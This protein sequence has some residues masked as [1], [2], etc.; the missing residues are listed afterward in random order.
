MKKIFVLLLAL[1]LV[2][3]FSAFGEGNTVTDRSDCCICGDFDYII[4][5][6]GTAKIVRY[7]G[8][9][10]RAVIPDFL[11]G[12][13]VTAI[14]K[15]AFRWS[16]SM[17]CVVLPD[18]VEYIEGNPFANCKYL[19]EF[20][21]SSDHPYLAVIDGVLFSKLDKRLICYPCMLITEYYT[22]PDGIQIIESYAFSNS[23]YLLKVEIPNSVS[24]I[25]SNPFRSCSKMT[26]F[27]FDEDHPY[28][29]YSFYEDDILVSRPDKRLICYPRGYDEND[30]IIFDGIEIIG[31]S[32]CLGCSHLTDISFAN[33]V[34]TIED[35]AFAGCSMTSI[36]I[37]DSVTSIGDYAFSLNVKAISVTIPKS[38]TSI[39]RGVFSNCYAL[40]SVSIPDNVTS[41]GDE[42]FYRCGSLE[43]IIIPNSVTNI[44]NNVF[45]GCPLLTVK[46]FL[47]SYAEKYCADQGISYEYPYE[48]DW[49]N[50]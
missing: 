44:G 6:D 42:A 15:D 49:L 19:G 17:D 11:D 3:P 22:I 14:G 1:S 40:T 48:I 23:T 50:N 41:I 28:L 9:A 27:I 2:F 29:D 25:G 31:D 4:L 45:Y 20:T 34:T 10:G 18:S 16:N 8:D 7:Y 5:D 38:V 33:S 32:A 37:P 13:K 26:S 43:T 36:K 21:V 35:R 39:G 12:L 47:N 46:V 30:L 24:Y